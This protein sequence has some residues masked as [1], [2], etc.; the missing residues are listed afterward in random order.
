ML[1][2]VTTPAPSTEVTPYKQATFEDW[3]TF[4]ALGGLLID[5]DDQ[6]IYKMTLTEFC[7]T[8]NV[9]K[10]TTLRWRKQTPDLETRIAQRRNEIIP[11]A[12]VTVAYNQ[13]FLLGMQTQDKRAAVE[14][15]KLFLGQFGNLELAAKRPPEPINTGQASWVELLKMKRVQVQAETGDGN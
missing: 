4:T 7:A 14:A 2:N 9:S 15:L 12:R 6:H 3:L 10:M 13:L 11:M 5:E 8:F 1:P